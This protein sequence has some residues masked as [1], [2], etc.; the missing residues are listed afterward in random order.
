MIDEPDQSLYPTSAR[1]LR[2]ELLHIATKSKIIFSTHSQYMI[3]ENCLDRHLIVEKKNDITVIKKE[4][5]NA[6]FSNDELLRRTIGTSI[7]ECLKAKN[8]IFE[9]WLDKE[10]FKIYGS[11]NNRNK[12]FDKYGTVYLSGISGVE[13]LVQILTLANKKFIIIADSDT[14]SKQKKVD[15]IHNYKEFENSWL[16]YADVCQDITTMEDFFDKSYI[17]RIIKENGNSEYIYD[18]SKNAIENIDK[19]IKNEKNKKQLIKNKLIS[20]VSKDSIL[21]D[22]GLFIQRIKEVIDEL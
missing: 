2:D 22:Y 15:F 1:F 9:G 19:A 4:D 8:I 7:F 3:D 11:F 6:P 10:L 14:I 21:K 5:K 20:G 12:E 17:E 16:A 18:S 13:T